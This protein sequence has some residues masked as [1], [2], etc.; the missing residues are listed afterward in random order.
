[1]DST[2]RTG[3]MYDL[4]EAIDRTRQA[5]QSASLDQPDWAAYISNLGNKLASRYERAGAISDMA[6]DLFTVPAMSDELERIFSNAGLI[7][8][9]YRGRLPAF[10]E[11]QYAKSWLKMG[12]ITSLEETFENVAVYPFDMETGP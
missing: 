1:M 6:G 2:E 9:P 7:S 10:G 8:S 3:A 12:I 4:D 11:A 5:A